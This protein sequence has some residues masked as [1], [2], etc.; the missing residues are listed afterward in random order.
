VSL[1]QIVWAVGLLGSAITN[2]QACEPQSDECAQVGQWN[3]S[4]ALGAGIMTNPLN[5]GDNFPLIVLPYVSYY[6]DRLFLE[7]TTLGYTLVDKPEFDFSLIVEPNAEQAYFERFHIRNIIAPDSPIDAS[8][9]FT[10]DDNVSSGNENGS[11]LVKE[12]VN[13]NDIGERDWTIDGGMLAH[14]YLGERHK[15]TMSWLADIG[16]V[17]KGQHAILKYTHQFSLPE[18]LPAKL[19]VNA[20]VHWQSQELVNY[21]YGLSAKDKLGEK[22]YYQGESTFSPFIS[23]AFNYRLNEDWQLKISAKHQFL[24]SGIR[25]SPIVDQNGSSAFFIGGLYEF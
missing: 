11:T 17:Y 24:G 1:K 19:Q 6:N 2:A 22:T 15:L 4:V 8:G 12:S 20:G 3:F 23:V 13:I 9:E 25:H 16:G 7:N 18:A 21:Y 5:G 14:W 10:G